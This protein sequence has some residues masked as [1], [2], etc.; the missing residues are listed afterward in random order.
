MLLGRQFLQEA[1][2]YT[3]Q[4]ARPLEHEEALLLTQRELARIDRKLTHHGGTSGPP[5][6]PCIN[7]ALDN[8]AAA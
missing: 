3:Y 6:P 8:E 1:F 2:S 5:A 4:L 7:A